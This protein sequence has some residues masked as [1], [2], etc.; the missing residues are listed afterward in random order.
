[1]VLGALRGFRVKNPTRFFEAFLG[2]EVQTCQWDESA[3]CLI[4]E[5]PAP[6]QRKLRP[7]FAVYPKPYAPCNGRFGT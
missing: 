6:K 2:I 4:S 3:S 1:M 5:N 7:L